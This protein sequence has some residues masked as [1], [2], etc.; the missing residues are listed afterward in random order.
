MPKNHY[1]VD[2]LGK[3]TFKLI[4]YS[5]WIKNNTQ[6]KTYQKKPQRNK[7]FHLIEQED[8]MDII[9]LSGPPDSIQKYTI[10]KKTNYKMYLTKYL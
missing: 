9:S 10:K 5:S 8:L 6:L 3:G 2:L 7:E 4:P 1:K